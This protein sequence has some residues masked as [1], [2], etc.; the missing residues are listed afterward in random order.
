VVEPDIRGTGQSLVSSH[1]PRQRCR[2]VTLR[3]QSSNRVPQEPVSRPPWGT[4]SPQPRLRTRFP[5]VRA[6]WGVL[7]ATRRA[8]F[9]TGE[10]PAN[11]PVFERCVPSG[12]H[13]SVPLGSHACHTFRLSARKRF[14]ARAE[15]RKSRRIGLS[16]APTL[17]DTVTTRDREGGIANGPS[18][19]RIEVMVWRRSDVS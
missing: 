9:R 2:R 10:F 1:T 5:S 6:V 13:N 3:H 16:N 19:F 18:R 17:A 7:S 11:S 4:S 14:V 12:G 8:S 15:S